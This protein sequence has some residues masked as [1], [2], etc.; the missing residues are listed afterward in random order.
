[1][2]PEAVHVDVEKYYREGF[3]TVPSVVDTQKLIELR[4]E[5]DRLIQL[6]TDQRDRYA[7]RIEWEVDHLAEEEKRGM[8]KVI[9][10]LEP[11]G[12]QPGFP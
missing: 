1:M 9:R 7:R 12:P 10:K 3:L 8:E 5:S 2:Q 11:I 6:I 4:A